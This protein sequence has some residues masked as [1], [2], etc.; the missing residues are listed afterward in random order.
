[1][2]M[3]YIDYP[4]AK[5]EHLMVKQTTT[6]KK[7]AIESVLDGNDM[8]LFQE[9][10]RT[11]PVSDVVIA[12]CIRLARATRPTDPLATAMVK[13]YLKWVPAPVPGSS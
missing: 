11:A 1:M 10:V 8:A 5:E 2:F 3:V 6:G 7:H 13:K 4:T 9:I 12:Y